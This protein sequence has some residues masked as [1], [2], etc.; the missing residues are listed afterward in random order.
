[1]QIKQVLFALVSVALL[2]AAGAASAQGP[3]ASGAAATIPER[4]VRPSMNPPAAAPG[5]MTAEPSATVGQSRN[6]TMAA[7]R[8]G[9]TPDSTSAVGTSNPQNSTSR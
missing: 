7:P 6:G 4:D 5:G 2:G 8:Q 9:M 1:M 3:G